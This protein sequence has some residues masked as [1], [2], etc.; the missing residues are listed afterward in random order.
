M[1][2]AELKLAIA[3]CRANFDAS[4]RGAVEQAA[5]NVRWE[6]FLTTARRHRVEALCWQGLEPVHDHIPVDIADVLQR[7]AN[8]IIAD[9]LRIAAESA[10]LLVIFQATQVPLLFLKG[11]TLGALAYPDPYRKMGWDIDLLVDRN[12]LV[13]AVGLL[14]SA[15]YLPV[16]PAEADERKLER[17]HATRK[18]SEWSHKDYGFRIDLHTRLA[19][20]PALLTTLGIGSAT[21]I[22]T[23]APGIALPT[24]AGLELFAYLC[25]HGASSNWFR[26]KWITDLAAWLHRKDPVEVEQLY[27]GS[28]QLGAGRAAGQALLLAQ[29]IYETSIG[30]HL[31][32]ALGEDRA[33]RWLADLA[34]AELC[35]IREP[36]ATFLG[37]A[38]IHLAQ[39]GLLPG[40]HFKSSE[41]A[42][43]L[44]IM[45]GRVAG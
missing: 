30:G 5:R 28:Q 45:I 32:R 13:A 8:Q 15:G 31:R 33:N 38:T 34:E 36:T 43:Q 6:R 21:Q 18:E 17:W 11:L 25:V 23:V 35:R 20:H 19:D 12:Q 22:V 42:R 2:D 7:R 27:N 24:F 39:F 29:R 1:H 9:N 10:R 37:T 16:T 14:R 41:A 4:H 3:A 40:W 44:R 26:L